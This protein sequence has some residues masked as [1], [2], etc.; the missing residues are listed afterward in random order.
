MAGTDS[1]RAALRRAMNE[2]LDLDELRAACFDLGIPYDT[3]GGESKVARIVNLLERLE[4][5]GRG[6]ELVLWLRENR[7]EFSWPAPYSTTIQSSYQINTASGDS[8]Q[9]RGLE[10]APLSSSRALAAEP[11]VIESPIR[12]EL[13]R[14]PAGEFLMGSDGRE[15]FETFD[16]EKPQHH[17]A[18]AEFFIGKFPVTVEQFDAFVKATGYRTTAEQKRSGRVRKKGWLTGLLGRTWTEVEGADWR[19]PL[20]PTS[21]LLGKGLHPVTQVSW[22][23]AVTFCSW[24]S[25]LTGLVFRL[26][27]EAEWEKAARGTDGRHFPWGNRRPE[28]RYCNLDDRNGDTTPVGKYPAGASPYGVL[29]MAGNVW[30]WTSSLWGT[31]PSKAIFTYPYVVNDGRE[32]ISAPSTVARVSRG[33]S[34]DGPWAVVRCTG[35]ARRSPLYRGNVQGFRVVVSVVEK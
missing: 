20:G 29:D 19:H 31:E 5:M 21:N 12:L 25:N 18:V 16:E 30:Q 34:Y 22:Y 9:L 4:R 27:T 17:V 1:A 2:R 10:P 15:G 28:D 33:G 8:T 26:P 35:R 11:L 14:I 3:L 24:L 23:D 32:D 13:V 6:G 7:S